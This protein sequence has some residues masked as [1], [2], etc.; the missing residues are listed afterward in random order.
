VLARDDDNFEESDKGG[1]GGGVILYYFCRDGY[2]Y[3]K[4][5]AKMPNQTLEYDPLTA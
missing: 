2:D 5:M 3:Q 1:G 4:E